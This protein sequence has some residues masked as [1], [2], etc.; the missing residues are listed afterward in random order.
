[1]RL[2][3]RARAPARV[4]PNVPTALE[5]LSQIDLGSLGVTRFAHRVP[6]LG[7]AV[8]AAPGVASGRAAFDS[9]RAKELACSGDPVILVRRDTT[10]E[11]I[12]G[13]AVAAGILTAVGGRTAHAAVVARQL[14]K[15]CLVGCHN[16][17]VDEAHRQAAI[18]DTNIRDGDWLSL[19]GD[20]GEVT[21]GKRDIVTEDPPEL[22]EVRG[23]RSVA[24]RHS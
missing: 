24:A 20:S 8:S 10:T 11:D 23:W 14:G 4:S 17:S 21:I 16:L 9:E 2:Q 5:R 19:D 6:P 1:M 22:E 13:F 12:A 18:G 15:V 3:I 7:H